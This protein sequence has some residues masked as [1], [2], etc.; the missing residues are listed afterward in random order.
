[1]STASR[2]A[3]RRTTAQR[4]RPKPVTLA[5]LAIVLVTILVSMFL[6][7]F[8]GW[9]FTAPRGITVK[10]GSVYASGLKVEVVGTPVESIA[11]FT[12]TAEVKATITTVTD[13]VRTVTV[14]VQLTNDVKQAP[15]LEG[16]PSPGAATPEPEPANVI[17]ASVKV[18]Y[19][20]KALDAPDK[21]IVGSGVGNYYNADGL[22]PGESATI[23]VVAI[24]VGDYESYEAFADGIWTDKDPIKTPEPLSQ[25]ERQQPVQALYSASRFTP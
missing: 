22:A 15:H 18:L 23:D 4:W 2:D 20:D 12:D 6:V 19:Y 13:T 10:P 8:G 9:P 17:N 5:I 25:N 24:G 7:L 3:G 11:T 16:T 14:T 1:L 21:E